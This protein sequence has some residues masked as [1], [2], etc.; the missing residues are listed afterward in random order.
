MVT[1][2]LRLAETG[3]M[4]SVKPGDTINNKMVRRIRI[5]SSEEADLAILIFEDG[6]ESEPTEVVKV[7]Y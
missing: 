2:I 1:I 6:S 4:T 3:E 7:L 5:S